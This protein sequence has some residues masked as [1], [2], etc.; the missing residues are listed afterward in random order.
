M[1]GN[2]HPFLHWDLGLFH[3]RNAYAA[4]SLVRESPSFRANPW[5]TE[6]DLLHSLTERILFHRSLQKP[7][8]L[9]FL[10][11]QLRCQKERLHAIWEDYQLISVEHGPMDRQRFVGLQDI[12]RVAINW[13]FHTLR[14]T[15]IN[16]SF[17]N[18]GKTWRVPIGT[19]LNISD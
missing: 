7:D 2:A 6:N 3:T 1:T 17:N 16:V 12:F 18:F 14:V 5:S 13:L 19:Q 9:V 4:R 15:M 10:Y 8:I 11:L